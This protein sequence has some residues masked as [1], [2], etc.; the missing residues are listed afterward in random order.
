MIFNH[1][2]MYSVIVILLVFSRT[3][4]EV[5]SSSIGS[6]S[7][8]R[9]IGDD[10]VNSGFHDVVVELNDTIFKDVLRETPANFALVEF[11]AHWLVFFYAFIFSLICY[12]IFAQFFFFDFWF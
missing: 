11:F 2:S 7:I 4:F 3:S 5:S 10:T 6:R 12:Q 8:L 1:S 9:Q